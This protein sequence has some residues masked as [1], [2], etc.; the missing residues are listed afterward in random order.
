MIPVHAGVVR[1]TR[2]AVGRIS[3]VLLS[4]Y[5]GYPGH[6][7]AGWANPS[8]TQTGQRFGELIAKRGMQTVGYRLWHIARSGE[9]SHASLSKRWISPTLNPPLDCL[10]KGMACPGQLVLAVIVYIANIIF[11]LKTTFR[12]CR[13]M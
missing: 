1:N 10:L 11:T 7:D 4:Q 9:P 5:D 2:N 6:T 8:P 13:E 12:L 3:K